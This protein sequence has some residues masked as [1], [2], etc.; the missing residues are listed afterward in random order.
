MKIQINS[1]DN[2]EAENILSR[3]EFVD[4]KN[5]TLI[6]INQVDYKNVLHSSSLMKTVVTK[7]KDLKTNVVF[8]PHI[9]IAERI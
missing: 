9:E 1:L 4:R 2:I 8:Y 5:S 6:L 3:A 7:V